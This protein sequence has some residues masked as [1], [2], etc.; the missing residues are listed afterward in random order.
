MLKK[1][2]VEGM[3]CNHCVNHVKNA[4]LDVTGVEDVKV[5]L[6]EKSALVKT[7]DEIAFPLL[8]E[9]V[10]EAGYQLYEH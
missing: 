10:K 1:Y 3:S 2:R 4:L 8:E 9:A 7:A 5:N 6:Q